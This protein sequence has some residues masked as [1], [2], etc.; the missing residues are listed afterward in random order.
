MITRLDNRNFAGDVRQTIDATTRELGVR[1]VA[2]SSGL[3]EGD[4]PDLGGEH[5][6][7]LEP[8]RIALL[9]RGGSNPHDVGEIWFFLDQELGIRHSREIGR[10]H[11]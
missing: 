11:V 2:I 3:G 6:K 5:F 8:P 7:R 10:A 9:T 4:L 1:A